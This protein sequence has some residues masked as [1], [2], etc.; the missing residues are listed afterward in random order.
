MIIILNI[1]YTVI[2]II[3]FIF[4]MIV[5]GSYKICKYSYLIKCVLFFFHFISNILPNTKIVSRCEL[6]ELVS[7][8]TQIRL[9]SEATVIL[10]LKMDIMVKR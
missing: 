7:V 3:V 10:I 5:F 4:N 8:I 6:F 1:I 2:F 9:S